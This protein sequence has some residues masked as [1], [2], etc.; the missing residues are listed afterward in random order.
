[1]PCWLNSGDSN[2]ASLDVPP[3]YTTYHPMAFS[4]E[5]AI[6]A[7]RQPYVHN[8]SFSNEDIEELEN[9]LR[10]RVDALIQKGME[11]EEAFQQ[12]LQRVGRLYTSESEYK[13]VY[14]GKIFRENRF[15]EAMVWRITMLRSYLLVAMRTLWK[16]KLLSAINIGGLA[17]GVTFCVW[18]FLYVEHEWSYDRFHVNKD[19]IFRVAFSKPEP[20]GDLMTAGMTPIPLAAELDSLYPDVEAVTRVA[21]RNLAISSDQEAS[22][23]QQVAFVDPALFDIFSFPVL[24]GHA[25]L[26]EPGHI[27]VSEETAAWYFGTTDPVGE[28]LTISIQG[29]LRVFSVAGVIQNTPTHS[30]IQLDVVL[31]FDE[32]LNTFP[33]MARSFWGRSWT[34]SGVETYAMLAPDT[35]VASLESSFRHLEETH[36]GDKASQYAFGLQPLPDIHL[37]KEVRA[38]WEPTSDPIYAAILATISI[39]IL[40]IACI[41]FVI[42]ILSGSV[43]RA[44]EVGVR[45]VV[46]AARKEIQFQFWGE[47]LLTTSIAMVLGLVLAR[48]FL[49]KFNEL[50]SKSLLLGMLD[51][52]FLWV[53]SIGLLVVVGLLA[54]A[55][56]ALLLSRLRPEAV[57][58]GRYG[59]AR[60][61]PFTRG[62]VTLQFTLSI[63]LLCATLGVARQI[64]Y[65]STKDLGYNPERLVVLP[66][67][68]MSDNSSLYAS[69]RQVAES[70]TAIENVTGTY[71]GS[72]GGMQ[73]TLQ[74]KNSE[75][76]AVLISPVDTNYMSFMDMEVVAGKELGHMTG[77]KELLVNEAFVEQMGW[78]DPIGQLIPLNEGMPLSRELQGWRVAG[79]VKDYHVGDLRKEIMPVILAPV[80][81]MYSRIN[82]IILRLSGDRDEESLKLLEESWQAVEQQTPFTYSFVEDELAAYYDNERRWRTIFTYSSGFALLIACSGLF[83]MAALAAS[84]RRKEIGIRKVL[85]ATT[86]HVAALLSREFVLL[87]CIAT[88]VAIP[89]A[90]MGVEFWLEQFAYRSDNTLEIY[91]LSGAVTLV[92]AL[93]TLSYHTLRAAWANP[94]D[95]IRS[96]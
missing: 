46:G 53:V 93:S 32:Y 45:K 13:K 44:R 81:L 57:L 15:A 29:E 16:R 30:S 31:P 56:P 5:K 47:A 37:N 1:M 54:G 3:L 77:A 66:M 87:I 61:R 2:L 42:L 59:L 33:D 80:S 18:L 62:L 25:A 65:L 17:I 75:D 51:R 84:R 6:A 40:L 82:A 50:A 88:L 70:H 72:L 67:D 48:V 74:N 95:S 55:Y 41:N 92:I 26:S 94:A 10:D 69:I 64:G 73:T 83:G 20:S 22:K 89:M 8:P 21:K 12:A 19:H 68:G 36:F 35:D 23:E 7:W 63:A 71:M 52:P 24:R 4:I 9:S 86:A 85:G 34:L 78:E 90:Y 27:L 49:F 39:L 11:E 91:V 14:W 96:E 38:G 79:V 58:K 43:D 60:R 28:V 76:M